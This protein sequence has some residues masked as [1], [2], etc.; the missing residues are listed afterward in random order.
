MNIIKYW[1]KIFI[2]ITCIFIGLFVFN[3]FIKNKAV[4]NYYSIEKRIDKIENINL[5][6]DDYFHTI[7]W[8]R[9]QGTSLDVPIILSD[10]GLSTDFPVTDEN[11]VWTV[12]SNGNFHNQINI[13]GHNIFNLSSKPMI[14]SDSFKRFEELMSFVYYD[15]SKKNKYIQLSL[16]DGEYL[17]KIFSAGFMDNDSVESLIKKDDYSKKELKEKVKYW[18]DNSIYDYRVLVNENDK[19]LTLL[20]CTRFYGSKKY[21]FYVTGRL[22]REGENP[23]DYS[24]SKNKKYDRINSILKGDSYNE[25]DI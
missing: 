20:T 13:F 3:S 4:S 19:F 24:V 18:K 7:G 14:K 25:E 5:D 2:F 22:L 11:Y 16:K 12:N 10:K 15:F 9:I 8:L 17:Y 1:K 21:M 6:L 23:I